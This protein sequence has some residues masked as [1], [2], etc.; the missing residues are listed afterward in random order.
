MK[1]RLSEDVRKS[2]REMSAAGMSQAAIGQELGVGRA[3]IRRV[4]NPE[5]AERD[6]ARS[7]AY[8]KAHREEIRQRDRE[9]RLRGAL[10]EGRGEPPFYRFLRELGSADGRKG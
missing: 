8:K 1:R 9:Y 10:D 7:L 6:R 3:S 4:V 5:A 2:I